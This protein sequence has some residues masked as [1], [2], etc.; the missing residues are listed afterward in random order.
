MYNITKQGNSIVIEH[1]NEKTAFPLNS[2]WLHANAG[3]NQ[4]VDVK[5][6]ASRK[7]LMSFRYDDCNLAGQDAQSTINNIQAIL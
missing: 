6:A 2:V 4:S 5:L 7:V 3:D 1:G